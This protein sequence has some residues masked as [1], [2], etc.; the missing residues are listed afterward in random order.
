[1]G[2]N[3]NISVRKCENCRKVKILYPPQQYLRVFCI[4]APT[5]RIWQFLYSWWLVFELN[6]CTVLKHFY[7]CQ[8]TFCLQIYR[9]KMLQHLW[10]LNWK[11][12]FYYS[13]SGNDCLGG[14]RA[15]LVPTG[16]VGWNSRQRIGINK[17]IFGSSFLWHKVLYQ[18]SGS[19]LQGLN[20]EIFW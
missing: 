4:S 14:N 5:S 9:L 2:L 1:M 3:I 18:R 17:G 11:F 6:L 10:K 12:F 20:E 15:F 19:W 13:V 16:L 7:L 8:K